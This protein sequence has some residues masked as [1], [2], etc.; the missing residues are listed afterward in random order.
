[1]EQKIILTAEVMIIVM[2]IVPI[3]AGFII[4]TAN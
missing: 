1:M 4:L 3:I 2:A